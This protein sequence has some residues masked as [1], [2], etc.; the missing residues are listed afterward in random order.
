MRMNAYGRPTGP[1]PDE[2]QVDLAVEVFRMLADATRV[3]LLW[4]LADGEAPVSE[5]TEA[6]GEAAGAR[7]PSTWRSCGWRAS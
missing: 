7:S 2:E 4:V 6:V 3:K 1:L 5:L